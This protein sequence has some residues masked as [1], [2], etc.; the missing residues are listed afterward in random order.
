MRHRK[1]FKETVAY[2]GGHFFHNTDH[3]FQRTKKHVVVGYKS[4]T[5]PFARTRCGYW[6]MVKQYRVET[7]D[8]IVFMICASIVPR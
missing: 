6:T 3:D 1:S 5:L 8:K 2:T 7:L 4:V